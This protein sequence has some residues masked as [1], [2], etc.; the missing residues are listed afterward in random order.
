MRFRFA[1]DASPVLK[2][3][4]APCSGV[5]LQQSKSDRV[6][7]MLAI[8]FFDVSIVRRCVTDIVHWSAGVL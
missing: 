7:S 6:G 4:A 8:S 2:D 3:G 1:C 5:S